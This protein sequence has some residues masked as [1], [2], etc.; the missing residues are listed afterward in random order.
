MEKEKKERG[1]CDRMNDTAAVLVHFFYINF[2]TCHWK[3]VATTL[4]RSVLR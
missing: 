4:A 1:A 2:Q 3:T